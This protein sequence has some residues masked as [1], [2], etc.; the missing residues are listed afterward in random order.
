[1]ATLHQRLERIE[2]GRV[3][4]FAGFGGFHDPRFAELVLTAQEGEQAA[5]ELRELYPR[6][7]QF[8]AALLRTPRNPDTPVLSST[9]T[10]RGAP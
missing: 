6:F 1:M 2:R 7:C 5:Q 9:E 10:G 4:R 3:D 8:F